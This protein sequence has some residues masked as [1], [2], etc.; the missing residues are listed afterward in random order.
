MSDTPAQRRLRTDPRTATAAARQFPPVP[1]AEAE[2]LLRALGAE[3]TVLALYRQ[4]PGYAALTADALILLNRSTV[5]R[6]PRPLEIRG[7]AHGARHN[8][9]VSVHGQHVTLWG[10]QTDKNGDLLIRA[11]AQGDVPPAHDPTAATATAD[12]SD[13]VPDSHK[14]VLATALRPGEKVRAVYHDGW[15]HAALTD[16]GLILLH[17]LVSPRATRV[18][19]PLH[20]LRR[21]SGFFDSVEILVDGRPHKLWG[22]KN[23]PKGALLEAAGDMVPAGS[24]LRPGR[25]TRLFTWVR[26][27]PVLTTLL[28]VPMAAGAIGGATGSGGEAGAPQETAHSTE[29]LVPDYEG[30]TLTTATARARAAGW[31]T[32]SASDATSA[33]RTVAP[34]DTGWQVCFQRPSSGE[35][36]RPASGTLT[37]YAVPEREECPERLHGPGRIVMPDLVGTPFGEARATLDG[38]GVGNVIAL[39]A[40]TGGRL[41]DEERDLDDWPVCRQDPEADAETTTNAFV[42]LWLIGPGE[43]CEKPSPSPT[44]TP[45]PKPKPKPKPSY[46][47]GSGGSSSGGNSGGSDDKSS[48]SGGGSTGGSSSNGGASGGSGSGGGGGQS[49]IGFGQFCSPVGATATTADGRPAKCFMGKDGQA[50]W[51]YNSG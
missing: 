18:A 40:H 47:G 17:S 5:T 33:L 34:G 2:A 8:V 6:V 13:S 48:T 3:E 30:A 29:I 15:G 22:S 4:G 11:A 24:P 28:A 44:P 14:G 45:E 49:G 32:V 36:V 10:S 12:G 16:S 35:T 39:H 51:G 38:L 42:R 37:L 20:I 43:P 50:R 25:R 46:G 9:D 41:L 7:P 21:A 23:D 27:H 26:R 19:G 31:A 1:V